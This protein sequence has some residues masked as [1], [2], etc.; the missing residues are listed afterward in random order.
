MISAENNLTQIIARLKETLY[1]LPSKE[2]TLKISVT[3]RVEGAHEIYV[4]NIQK[5]FNYLLT[6]NNLRLLKTIKR[7]QKRKELEEQELEE[8]E[9]EEE[10]FDDE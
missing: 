2:E 1:S 8:Q 7:E 5:N 9:L 4:E 10:E 6:R 3:E